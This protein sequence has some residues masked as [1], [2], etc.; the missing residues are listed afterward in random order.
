MLACIQKGVKASLSA[1]NKALAGC[2]FF[3]TKKKNAIN[4]F[5]KFGNVDEYEIAEELL[6]MKKANLCGYNF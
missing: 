2:K 1:N 6:R 5:Q 4:C 3:L